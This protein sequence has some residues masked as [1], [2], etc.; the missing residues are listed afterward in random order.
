MSKS[1]VSRSLSSQFSLVTPNGAALE[2]IKEKLAY[3][4]TA[5]TCRE[6][7]AVPIIE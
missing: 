7:E 5:R 4:G 6:C 2:G 3:G 1:R